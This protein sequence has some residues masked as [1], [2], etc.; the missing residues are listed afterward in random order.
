MISNTVILPVENNNFS[1]LGSI[2]LASKLLLYLLVF[3]HGEE[4]ERADDDEDECQH[5]VD[6]PLRRQEDRFKLSHTS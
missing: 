2:A 3:C 5:E 6:E 4:D 1:Y